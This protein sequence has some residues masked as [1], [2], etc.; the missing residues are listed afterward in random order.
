[1][2]LRLYGPKFAHIFLETRS[3]LFASFFHPFI[4]GVSL[5]HIHISYTYFQLF[6]LEIF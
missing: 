5:S 6:S 3:V 2:Y 4:I 1:M